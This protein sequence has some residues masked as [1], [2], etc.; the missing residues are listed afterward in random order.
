V[1]VTAEYG[2]LPL[3]DLQVLYTLED[4]LEDADSVHTF[5]QDFAG[6]WESRYRKLAL[7]VQA[8]DPSAAK[9]AVLSVRIASTMIGAVQLAALAAHLEE[10]IDSVELVAAERLLPEIEETGRLSVLALQADY[11]NRRSR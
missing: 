1:S 5:V 3:V 7:A 9:D 4:E 8:C 2:Q 10:Q 11:V 6:I